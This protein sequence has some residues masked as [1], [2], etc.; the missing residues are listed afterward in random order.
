M[1]RGR[2]WARVPMLL[3]IVIG[4]CVVA[5]LTAGFLG[6]LASGLPL[7]TTG[8]GIAGTSILVVF[9]ACFCC[10]THLHA[11]GSEPT[12]CPTSCDD[13]DA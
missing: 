10:R 2:A 6:W 11:A 1:S 3:A 12:R 4:W 5:F 7:D 8:E 13:P 9:G